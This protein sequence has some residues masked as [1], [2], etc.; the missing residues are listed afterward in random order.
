MPCLAAADVGLRAAG[1]PS[2]GYSPERALSAAPPSGSTD[3]DLSVFSV[4][5]NS[6]ESNCMTIGAGTWLSEDH[7]TSEES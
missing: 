5:G 4:E 1:V 6:V 2:D 3:V 7:S